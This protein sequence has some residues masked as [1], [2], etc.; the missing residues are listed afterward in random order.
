M[1]VQNHFC[2]IKA[3]LPPG[4]EN[5]VLLEHSHD[6]SLMICYGGFYTKTAV[7]SNCNRDP[8]IAKNI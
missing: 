7:L 4:F 8:N 3:W 1:H 2:F 5:K 6:H